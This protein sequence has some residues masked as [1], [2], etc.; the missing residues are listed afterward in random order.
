M[1]GDA[2]G[3][4]EAARCYESSTFLSFF[5]RFAQHFSNKGLIGTALGQRGQE[6]PNYSKSADRSADTLVRV[7]GS[8]IDT[9]I[10]RAPFGLIEV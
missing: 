7:S 2:A 10:N 4:A 6:C 1:I 8:Y 3:L 9:A 5:A